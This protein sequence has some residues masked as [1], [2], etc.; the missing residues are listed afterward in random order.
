MYNNFHIQ[1]QSDYT[2]ESRENG[3]LKAKREK[4]N[5]DKYSMQ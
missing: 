5:H 3:Q 1:R 4:G 2:G